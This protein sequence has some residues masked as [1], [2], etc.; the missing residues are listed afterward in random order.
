MVFR[1]KPALFLFIA[2][3]HSC[4]TQVPQ[5]APAGIVDSCMSA[6]QNFFREGAGTPDPKVKVA[7]DADRAYV[8]KQHQD[9]TFTVGRN[10]GNYY[11]L[12]DSQLNKKIRLKAT[13][14]SL[15]KKEDA[16]WLDAGGG[17]GYA[18]ETIS[19][20]KG[21]KIKSTLVSVETPAT[22]IGQRRKVLR[23][24]FIEDIQDDLLPK[25]DLI[26]D[27]YG[28]MAY[29]SRPDLV[30]MKYIKNLK[31]E[32]SAFIHLGDE[33]DKF[34]EYHKVLTKNGE[35]ISLTDWI[36]GIAGL[37]VEVGSSRLFE[38]DSMVYKGEKGRTLML[39]LS[40]KADQIKV[41]ELERISFQEGSSVR[42]FVVP[43][44]IF[45]EIDY[46]SSD[47]FPTQGSWDNSLQRLMAIFRRGK[48]DHA[49]L[50]NLESLDQKSWAHFAN[51]KL[52]FADAKSIPISQGYYSE[53]SNK[54]IVERMLKLSQ[55]NIT[56][57]H[58]ELSEL[59]GSKVQLITDLN[60]SFT[61]SNTPSENLKSYLQALS[62]KGT[63]LINLGPENQGLGGAKIIHSNGSFDVLRHWFK[64]IKGVTVDVISTK[65]TKVVTKKTLNLPATTINVNYNG[66]LYDFASTEIVF[67][68]Y[69]VIKIKNKDAIEV[70][71]LRYLGK[72]SS[73][74]HGIEQP[75]YERP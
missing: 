55:N 48:N 58:T 54:K 17:L 26:T 2:L 41:P 74:Q 68:E 72:A 28:P 63:I 57:T 53:S 29:S 43:R 25:S 49:F 8:K 39:Q 33:L 3:L 30:L 62:D 44:M 67:N 66:P 23:G 50:K 6:I 11:A 1:I 5:R 38:G 35:V 69:V 47:A 56:P 59:T 9:S 16:H 52:N 34:G 60:G 22:N 10:I 65:E 61:Q 20:L 32:G 75:L 36:K 19:S 4:A 51:Q 24:Q 73:N 37:K 71:E 7:S 64:Q 40:K 15:I 18:T 31:P 14:E 12:I 45:K 27:V 46:R 42:G 21:S 70:P 13:L